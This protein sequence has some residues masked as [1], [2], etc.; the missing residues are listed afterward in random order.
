MLTLLHISKKAYDRLNWQLAS[1][2]RSFP[3]QIL[4][5]IIIMETLTLGSLKVLS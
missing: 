5:R 3:A 1:M 2:A 4:N